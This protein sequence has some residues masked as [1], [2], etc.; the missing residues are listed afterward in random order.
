[1]SGIGRRIETAVSECFRGNYEASATAVFQAIDA[2]GRKRFPRKGV[3]ARFR[4]LI[5]EQ[6]DI[7]TASALGFAM[8]GFSVD[9][10]TLSKAIYEF[11]R[12]PLI[13]EAELSPR[14]SF[15]NDDGLCIG[16]VWNLP[17]NFLFGLALGVIAAK[18]NVG[19]DQRYVAKT[20]FWGHTLDLQTLWGAEGYLRAIMDAR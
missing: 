19:E 2:T 3:G 14:M 7:V 17:P 10:V 20:R 6:Q 5:D 12:N 16:E 11:A 15:S 1:M 13:H 8:I 9:G 18:E 4:G